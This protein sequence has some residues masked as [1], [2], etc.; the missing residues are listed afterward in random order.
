MTLYINK[1]GKIEPP[2]DLLI[3]CLTINRKAKIQHYCHN[4]LC[5]AAY[6]VQYCGVQE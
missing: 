6:D 5:V 2:F 4:M 3:A 1:I